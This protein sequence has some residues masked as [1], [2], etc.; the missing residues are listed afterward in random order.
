[1]IC[2][3]EKSLSACMGRGGTVGRKAGWSV[4]VYHTRGADVTEVLL[5]EGEHSRS[6]A[7]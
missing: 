2:A 7:H 5:M 1:M 3:F 4:S 6:E